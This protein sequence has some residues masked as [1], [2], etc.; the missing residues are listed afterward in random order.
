[1]RWKQVLEQTPCTGLRRPS[2]LE[3]RAGKRSSECGH[4]AD[5]INSHC[6]THQQTFVT[7]TCIL[8]VFF[9]FFVFKN[10]LFGH[11]LRS[12]LTGLANTIKQTHWHTDWNTK[13]NKTANSLT[14]Q[15]HSLA[16]QTHWHTHW[17]S[18]HNEMANSLT[19]QTHW[20]T[21]LTGTAK[22]LIQYTLTQQ[23][24][25]R[26]A[27]FMVTKLSQQKIT[28]VHPPPPPSHHKMMR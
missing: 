5:W 27:N 11:D 1:M 12:S 10:I 16:H 18:K 7:W 13:H 9:L 15:T 2:S 19:Q 22:S 14:Q 24:Q 4:G 21:K 17:H 20:H 8:D 23:I 28:S 26:T 6:S 25:T 3:V